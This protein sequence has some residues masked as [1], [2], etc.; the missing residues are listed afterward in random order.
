MK[1]L[2]IAA[3]VGLAAI[4]ALLVYPKSSGPCGGPPKARIQNDLKAIVAAAEIFQL[5]CGSYP[6]TLEEL[7]SGRCEGGEDA[8]VSLESILDPWGNESGYEL[9]P[10]GK[11]RAS[12][13]GRDGVPGGSGEDEDLRFPEGEE[14]ESP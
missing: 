13:L 12:C 14:E 5:H 11:P 6:R 3:A 7:R 2:G 1:L 10:S 4:V 8:G 9:S